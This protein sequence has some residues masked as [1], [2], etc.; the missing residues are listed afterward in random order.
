M[1]RGDV[2]PLRD[3]YV[4]R[5]HHAMCKGTWV[6]FKCRVAVRRDTWR[7]VTY[8][9]PE[10]IGD[11]RGDHVRC[12]QCRGACQ[13]LG[14]SIAIPPKRELTSWRSLQ[15]KIA[16]SRQDAAAIRKEVTTR[17]KHDLE[18]RIRDI[19]NRPANSGRTHLIKKLEK[20]LPAA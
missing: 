7:H 12:P 15:A 16:K 4:K 20:K 3:F 19:K 10:L 9:H 2:L 11:T 8:L 17:K 5:H 1:P 6:C 13:F 18:H 14:P